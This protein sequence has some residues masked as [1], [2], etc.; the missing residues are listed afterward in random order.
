MVFASVNYSFLSQKSFST[1]NKLIIRKVKC[2]L[3]NG[4]YLMQ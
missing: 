4:H 1:I 3:Q 2:P